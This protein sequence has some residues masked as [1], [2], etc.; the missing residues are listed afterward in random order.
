LFEGSPASILRWSLRRTREIDEEESE[1]R[2]VRVVESLFQRIKLFCT[3]KQTVVGR[4][5]SIS[6]RCLCSSIETRFLTDK[7]PRPP[8]RITN[9]RFNPPLLRVSLSLSQLDHGDVLLV[10]LMRFFESCEL[11]VEHRRLHEMALTMRHTVEEEFTS[12]L[13]YGDRKKSAQSERK[14]RKLTTGTEEKGEKNER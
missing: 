4:G 11:R 14:R 10:R 7:S 5:T 13:D 9:D 3:S 2:Q 12:T 6:H 1:A 8:H